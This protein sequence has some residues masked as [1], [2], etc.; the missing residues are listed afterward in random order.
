MNVER[1][2]ARNLARSASSLMGK[3]GRY[4]S[5]FGGKFITLGQVL[6]PSAADFTLSF[7]IR[8]SADDVGANTTVLS[9]DVISAPR[10]LT[11]GTDVLRAIYANTG[12]G[13]TTLNSVTPIQADTEMTVEF[14]NNSTTG[15]QLK[16]NGTEEDSSAAIADHTLFGIELVG[17][18]HDG[19]FIFQGQ[20]W[21][22]DIPD[23]AGNTMYHID[24]GGGLEVLASPADASKNGVWSSLPQ[25]VFR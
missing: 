20:I 24:E 2:I 21:D 23:G 4:Y 9:R 8:P 15:A 11:S 16:I 7:K 12:G 13:T 1:P 22:L 10:F 5:I 18:R 14:V 19:G 6:F 25:R 17:I 3:D